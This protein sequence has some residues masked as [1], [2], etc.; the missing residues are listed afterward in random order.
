M[1]DFI[2]EAATAQ[3][4]ARRNLV[5]GVGINDAWYMTQYKG[6]KCP[7]YVRWVDFLTRCYN[8]NYQATRPTYVG[9]SVEESWLR[10]STFRAWMVEQ[11]WQ[12][13]QLYKDMLHQGNK[14]YSAAS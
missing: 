2:Q 9:C 3:S 12:G 13:L 4:L 8:K 10:F 1:G 11:E 14:F 6:Q 7:Y 5:R